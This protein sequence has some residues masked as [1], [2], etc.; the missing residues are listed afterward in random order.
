M[1]SKVALGV[2]ALLGLLN[3]KS[4]PFAYTLRM[5]PA[6]R[7]LMNRLHAKAKQSG[8]SLGQVNDFDLLHQKD[9]VQKYTLTFDDLDTDIHMNNAYDFFNMSVLT[10]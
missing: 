2:L 1:I 5:I 7:L 10:T 9:I 6:I 3:I 4:L 8:K